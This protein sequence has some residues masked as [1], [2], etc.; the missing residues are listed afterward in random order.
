[1]NIN[2]LFV[3]LSLFLNGCAAH[4][5]SLISYKF[6]EKA[7]EITDIDEVNLGPVVKK[8]DERVAAGDKVI[9]LQINSFGGS[10]FDGMDFIQH[11]ENAKKLN[12]IQ[13]QCVVNSKAMSMGL[14]MLESNACDI[15]LATNYA[16][17]LAHNGSS[18]ARGT[19]DEIEESAEILKV[20]NENMAEIIGNR[21]TIGLR[22]YKKK[23]E[24][25]A[26]TFGPKEALEVGA[27]D[28]IVDSK[29]LPPLYELPPI[30]TLNF[31]LGI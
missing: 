14:V 18:G 8:F 15:R 3:F 28:E 16:T 24:R 27:I 21:L 25:R 20:L 6:P 2:Y 29:D 23:I 4:A 19:I 12:D 30:L 31:L 11:V 13:I 10:I 7:I 17:I 9:M 1:M 26:W 22:A 5:S